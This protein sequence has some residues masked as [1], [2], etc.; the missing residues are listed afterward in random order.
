MKKLFSVRDTSVTFDSAVLVLRIAIAAL[1]LVHGIPK[2]GMLFS[3]GEILFPGMFGLSPALSLTLT[4]FAEVICSVFVLTG[5]G[6]RLAV[7]PLIITM[8]VAI[9]VVHAND[10]FTNKEL[11]VHYLFTYV[12]LLI[13]GSGKYSLDYLLQSKGSKS[14]YVPVKTED[15]TL[16]IY[17]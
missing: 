16:S 1:M 14:T 17:Q 10:P 15:P 8:L 9:L 12:V 5:F 7:I 2:M 3:S 13:T 6:T 4:V 11:A